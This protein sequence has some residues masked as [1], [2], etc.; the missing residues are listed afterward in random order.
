LELRRVFYRAETVVAEQA[1]T[2]RSADTGEV[3]DRQAVA[4]VFVVRDGRVAR[5][6]RHP[7]LADALHAAGLDETDVTEPE[8]DKV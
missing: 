5:V 7:S 8:Q 2:W 4:S 3:S 6:V 1:A